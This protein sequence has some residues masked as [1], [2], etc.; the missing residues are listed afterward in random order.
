MLEVVEMGTASLKDMLAADL[1]IL[2]V[3]IFKK[4]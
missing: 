1:K 2:K 3:H 4:L